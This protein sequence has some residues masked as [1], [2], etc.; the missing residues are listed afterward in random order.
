M[1]PSGTEVETRPATGAPG[2]M[3]TVRAVERRRLLER[4]GAKRG[5]G[6]DWQ[7]RARKSVTRT[8]PHS[9]GDAARV[10][11]VTAPLA[12]CR[13]RRAPHW[14]LRPAKPRRRLVP[15]AAR[16]VLGAAGTTTGSWLAIA[17][18]LATL[19]GCQT[20]SWEQYMDAAAFAYQDGRTEEAE[21]FFLLA[22]Q[23]AEE[24]EDTD[25]RRALTLGNLADLYRAQARDEEAES[26]YLESLALLERIDGPD[27]PRVARFV[28]DVAV[29]YTDL[30]R[31]EEAE[32]L[33]WRALEALEWTHGFY[34][35][36]VLE[37]RTMLAGFLLQQER[38]RE[39]EPLYVEVL[40]ILLDT[41]EP[42]RDQDRVLIVLDEY[43]ALLRAT[44]RG[45]E[46]A[47]AAA[48]AS[49][50]RARF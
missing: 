12:V 50:I 29:F 41:P 42:D 18:A 2:M 1:E 28:A 19:A 45:D 15:G 39:A 11:C 6:N 3:P 22:A 25:P 43:A 20:Q 9:T 32:P 48:R 33:Y 35:D 10:K 14:S 24:F 37:L 47:E 17:A 8:L 26:A 44:G 16:A 4:W 34:H 40:A 38:Y 5:R 36:D 21:S 23:V 46:A 49:G 7:A 31:V 30:G 27:S 13:R